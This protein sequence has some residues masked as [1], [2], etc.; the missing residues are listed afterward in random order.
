MKAKICMMP[1]KI[2]LLSIALFFGISF[3][4]AQ[5][6]HKDLAPVDP[7][8]EDYDVLFSE[9]DSFLDSLLTPRSYVL[10]SVGISNS[11]YNFEL[12][13]SFFLEPEKRFTYA[14]TLSYFH[15][16]GFGINASSAIINDGQ[17]MNPYMS[18]LTGSYDHIKNMKLITGIS[19]SRFFTKK[20]LSFYTS[21]LQN[22]LYAYF[23]YRNFWVK[24]SV[25]VNYGWG[26][27]SEY[28][29]REERINSIRLRPNGFTRINSKESVTDFTV[30]TSC[31]KDFYWLDVLTGNDFIRLTPQISFT[32]GTQ[33]F[34]FNQTSKTYGTARVSGNNILYS[35]EEVYLD[36]Q[37]SFQPLSLTGFIKTEYSIGK[38]FIQSQI[39]FDY[40]FPA[41]SNNFSTFFTLN[42]GVI[43]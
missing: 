22:E 27:R 40:Y 20:D 35:S 12:K 9:L 24:P 4:H 18:I 13:N 5:K 30:S 10:F 43:F 29:E 34:G 25:S 1:G 41:R 6:P 42:A 21:P 36:D 39:A 28:S 23:T 19:A 26:S 7:D 32:S 15:K 33:R 37:L 2:R 14:P 8:I 16:S 3:S 11:I 17:K 31:R 38:V